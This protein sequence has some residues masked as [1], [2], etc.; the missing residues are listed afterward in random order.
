MSTAPEVIVLVRGKD[1][2]VVME[3]EME[4]AHYHHLRECELDAAQV[5]IRADLAA[6][7]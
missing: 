4:M 3:M 7:L 1:K 6:G 2:F 5:Q